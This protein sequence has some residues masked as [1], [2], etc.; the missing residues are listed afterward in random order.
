M[1][2]LGKRQTQ[3]VPVTPV[4]KKPKTSKEHSQLY[5]DRLKADPDSY[6]LYR[7]FE[8]ERINDYRNNRQSSD[9]KQG[10]RELQGLRQQK[11]RQKLKDKGKVTAQIKPTTWHSQEVQRR[12]WREEKQKQR[13]HMNHQ[14]RSAINAQRRKARQK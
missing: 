1:E 12:K 9:A 4:K 3:K 2:L 7:K 13:Q 5:R 10:N 8:T 14:K 11:Y 6:K